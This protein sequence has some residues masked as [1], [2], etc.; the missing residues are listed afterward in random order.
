MRQ[1]R[2]AVRYGYVPVMM[3]GLNGLALWLV[4][5]GHSY[6]WTAASILFAAIALSF[7]AERIL[8]Y[9]ASWNASHDDAGKD[10]AHAAVYEIQNINA[11][12]LLPVIAMFRPW[13][14]VWP[15]TWPLA[16]QVL[17]AI[18]VTDLGLTLLHY[19]SH[20]WMPLWRM[21]AIHHGVHR[22]YGFNGFIRHPLH[23]LIDLLLSSLPL[24]LLGLPVDVALLLG[25]AVS[26]QLLVQHSNVDYDLGPL[27]SWLA[28][29]PLHRL[30]HVNWA[31]EGDVNFGLFL[32]FWDRLLGTL[33]LPEDAPRPTVGD[34]GVTGEPAFTQDYV[35]QL[36]LPF[37]KTENSALEVA[38]GPI[39]AS[40]VESGRRPSHGP[41]T[42]LHAE[43]GE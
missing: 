31:G 16:L 33:R 7:I 12:L 40:T 21:H 32:T 14:G 24:A 27:Q 39:G 20:K 28:I 19:V 11:T 15:T 22:V 17:F 43:A 2:L 26:V 18:V 30:H 5:T 34:I 42:N 13:Q 6:V 38:G 3:L 9:E 36:M 8:P 29:G 37:R 23:Q 4:A 35:Q 10:I 25:I 1:M 41:R